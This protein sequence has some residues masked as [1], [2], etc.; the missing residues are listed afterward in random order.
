MQ[1]KLCNKKK[2]K[3][4]LIFLSIGL[5]VFLSSCAFES[6]SKAN[7]SSLGTMGSYSA[8]NLPRSAKYN[9]QLGLGYLEQGDVERAK[10][11]L[12]KAINQAPRMPE[13]HYNLAH[14][15]Y[16]IGEYEMADQH[17]KQAIDYSQDSGNNPGVLGTARNNYG[18]FLCQTKKYQEAEQQFL[19]A[20]DDSSY[21]DTASAYENAGLC[22]QQAGNKQLAHNYFDKAI[23]QNPLSSKSLIELS[24]YSLE[25]RDYAKAKTYMQRYN[26]IASINKRS[27]L[28]NLK[29]AKALGD[30]SEINNLNA[31]MKKQFPDIKEQVNNLNNQKNMQISKNKTI[32]YNE[33]GK[34]NKIA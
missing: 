4:T 11:K 3:L 9:V 26:Q 22:A 25:N 33:I 14:F 13:A 5:A 10:D 15:Y 30:K 2:I 34:L 32:K 16:L 18:V 19:M 29:L 12:L 1:V 17:F 8:V 27:L 7:D 23:K 6:D 31:I 28:I 21:I 20:I 24:E